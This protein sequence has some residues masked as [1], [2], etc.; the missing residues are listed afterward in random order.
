MGLYLHFPYVIMVWCSSIRDSFDI[1]FTGCHILIESTPLNVARCQ[2]NVPEET[3]TDNY[4]RSWYDDKNFY[5]YFLEAINTEC[6]QRS[7]FLF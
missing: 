3:S 2:F 6:I 1:F 5:L 7:R 4:S